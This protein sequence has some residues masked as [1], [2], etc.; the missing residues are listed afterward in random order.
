MIV[1]LVLATTLAGQQQAA[2]TAANDAFWVPRSGANAIAIGEIAD[3]DSDGAG[4]V[5]VADATNAT[6][7][8]FDRR[9]RLLGAVGRRGS[10]AGEYRAPHAVRSMGSDR[11]AVLDQGLAR[12]YTY[13]WVDGVPRLDGIAN[14][15]FEPQD[16]CPGPGRR[17]VVY[18]KYNGKRLHELDSVG[19]VRQSAVP[20]PQLPRLLV[21]FII[22]GRVACCP[23]CGLWVIT[24]ESQLAFELFSGKDVGALTPLRVDS[25]WPARFITVESDDDKRFTFSSEPRG[26]HSPHRARITH[27]QYIV[28]AHVRGRG[29]RKQDDSVRVYGFSAHE[30]GV[31]RRSDAIGPIFPLSDGSYLVRRRGADPELRIV[32]RISGP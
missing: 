29:D 12:I 32:A 5:Y 23:D 25:I 3:A 21:N 18:G 27:P 15:P 17:F 6:V 9:M 26:Y 14:V 1:F 19:N 22:D 31:K 20:L 10:R 28:P 11:F 30:P 7:H 8:V 2:S 16:F 24:S 4:R 13:R